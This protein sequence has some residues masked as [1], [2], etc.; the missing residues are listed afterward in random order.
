MQ[1]THKITHTYQF[2]YVHL[3]ICICYIYIDVKIEVAWTNYYANK[4]IKR[5]KGPFV[6]ISQT[7]GGACYATFHILSGLTKQSKYLIYKLEITVVI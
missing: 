3:Y 7:V 5:N 2:L 6:K 4:G 1:I